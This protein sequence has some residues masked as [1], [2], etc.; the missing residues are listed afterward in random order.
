[1]N[2]QPIGT[3]PKTGED[4][5]VFQPELPKGGE[6]YKAFWN[7]KGFFGEPQWAKSDSYHGESDT[8]SSV[9]EPSHWMPMPEPP[10]E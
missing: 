7:P 5:L 10:K 4:I 8:Y 3:A 6:T 1:M 2:W 9:G